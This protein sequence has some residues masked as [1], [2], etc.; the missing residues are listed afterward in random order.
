VETLSFDDLN[1]FPNPF[2]DK[3][4]ITGAVVETRHATSLQIQIQMQI[5]NAAG[6][7]VHVQNIENPD[8]VIGLE[9]LP[10]G[11]YIFRFDKDG[12]IG[13]ERVVKEWTK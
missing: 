10:A 6:A 4:R 7:L 11:V 2:T 1:V 3:V 8:E 12:N 5:I 13:S 9:N